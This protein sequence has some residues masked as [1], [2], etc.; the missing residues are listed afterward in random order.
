MEGLEEYSKE[1]EKL[2][3]EMD[4]L[5]YEE[6]SVRL[7][8][9]WKLIPYNIDLN[10]VRLKNKVAVLYGDDPKY[11][12]DK[13][14]NTFVVD[15]RS[16]LTDEQIKDIEYLRNNIIKGSKIPPKYFGRDE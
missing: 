11:M 8:E 9:L 12:E 3:N 2:F 5:T 7:K 13:E 14:K 15:V 16:E 6:T 4:N 1:E 10:P